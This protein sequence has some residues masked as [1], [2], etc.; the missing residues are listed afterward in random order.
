MATTHDAA[1]AD[2]DQ[3]YRGEERAHIQHESDIVPLAIPTEKERRENLIL[4]VNC[5]VG[6]RK[7]G[8]KFPARMA[9]GGALAAEGAGGTGLDITFVRPEGAMAVGQMQEELGG[10]QIGCDQSDSLG[11][12]ARGRQGAVTE[13][14][15]VAHG[16]E[17]TVH[18]SGIVR[19]DELYRRLIAIGDQRWEVF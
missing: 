5:I 4:P 9:V 2:A 12:Q 3:V 11:S 16:K 15:T 8:L 10:G 19:R 7:T 17:E 1:L 13:V 6:I 18:L 14:A